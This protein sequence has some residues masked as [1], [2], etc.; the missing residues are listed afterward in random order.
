M[1]ARMCVVIGLFAHFTIFGLRASFVLEMKTPWLCF[2]TDQ[3]KCH[4][5]TYC[6]S[7]MCATRSTRPHTPVCQIYCINEVLCLFIYLPAY[8]SILL[9][10][11]GG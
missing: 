9:V 6:M 11:S 4:T 7:H 8:K 1:C 5:R 10:I 2:F 3:S